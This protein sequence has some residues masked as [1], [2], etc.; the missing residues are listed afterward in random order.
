MKYQGSKN[1][2]AKQ[3]L[4]VILQDERTKTCENWIEP[5][6]GGANMI[7]KVPNNFRKIGNDKNEYIIEM[8]KALQSGWI[9]PEYVSDDEYRNVRLNKDEF[10]EF[11][12]GFVGVGCSFAGKWFGGFARNVKKDSPNAE[13]LNSTTRNYCGE[14][15]RNL[16]KQLQNIKEVLFTSKDYLELYIP[17]SSIIY[18]DP[19]Y[20]GTTKYKDDFDHD[21][22]WKW[23]NNMVDK[24]LVVYVSEYNAPEDWQ[25]VWSKE[26]N[27]SLD[28]NTG[29]KKAIEKL[30]TKTLPNA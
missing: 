15:K 20:L 18:C 7:D 21:K 28:L 2:I 22:F 11:L 9:P 14:S 24:G 4:S 1:R 30:F 26:V 3:L 12:V 16:L 13:V 19:P 25:C 27:S 17:E 5:F 10:D 8:F 29:G 6:V 23:C